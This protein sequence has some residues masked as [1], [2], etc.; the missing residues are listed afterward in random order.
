VINNLFL[1]KLL[2]INRSLSR[3]H[4]VVDVGLESRSAAL[5]QSQKVTYRG[6]FGFFS[7]ALLCGVQGRQGF[8][9][10]RSVIV[11][12]YQWFTEYSHLM[13]YPNIRTVPSM[14]D[15]G[16]NIGCRGYFMSG[17]QSEWLY[18]RNS[19]RNDCYVLKPAFSIQTRSDGCG[20]S[21]KADITIR[22]LGRMTQATVYGGDGQL[23]RLRKALLLKKFILVSE[24][25]Q[26]LV[27]R[28]PAYMLHDDWP[29]RVD[30]RRNGYEFDIRYYLLI[31]WPWIIGFV[32]L[33]MIVLPFAGI[34]RADMMLILGTLAAGLASYK[35]KFD[36]SPQ[37][38][39]WQ[40]EPRRRWGENM[41]HI[42]R[43]AFGR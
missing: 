7:A 4:V 34:Q 23:K 25:E 28:R 17:K 30:I 39:F 26:R 20:R 8:I 9:G 3:Y 31:P 22:H 24:T 6:G 42:V 14:G 43:E 32:L 36:C 13:K 40:R 19:R 37:A 27:F 21:V 16:W 10:V 1:I 33:M 11:F 38:P 12:A 2:A 5:F 41:E 18:Y 15:S 35:Q 29:M